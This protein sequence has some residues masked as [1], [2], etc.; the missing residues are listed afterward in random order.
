MSP[1]LNAMTTIL[2]RYSRFRLM[3]YNHYRWITGHTSGEL[4]VTGY[5]YLS[6]TSLYNLKV[7]RLYITL[8]WRLTTIIIIISPPPVTNKGTRNA[9]S[10]DKTLINLLKSATLLRVRNSSSLSLR[11]RRCT[12]STMCSLC[13]HVIHPTLP[14]SVTNASLGSI[15]SSSW[16]PL[17]VSLRIRASSK[18]RTSPNSAP[19]SVDAMHSCLTT[20]NMHCNIYI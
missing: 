13:D 10:L 11:S 16:T 19:M 8:S 9:C 4:K 18:G 12:V 3:R 15:R 5:S 20:V 1:Y 7:A 2:I 17:T 6:E 14:S